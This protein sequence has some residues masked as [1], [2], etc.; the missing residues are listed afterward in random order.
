[1][2]LLKTTAVLMPSLPVALYAGEEELE[3]VLKLTRWGFDINV[4]PPVGQLW[5][6]QL[7]ITV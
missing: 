4:A 7:V 5:T 6:N 2:E 1:M 3:H